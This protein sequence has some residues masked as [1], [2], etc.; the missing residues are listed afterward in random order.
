MEYERLR[1]TVLRGRTLDVGG[2]SQ[3]TYTGLFR[4]E[5]A[6][7]SINISRSVG[8]TWIA[9]LNEPLSFADNEF[10]NVISLNTLEH[11]REDLALLREMVRVLR[12]GGSL[13]L[14]VPFLYRMH[15]TPHDYHRHTEQWWSH[16][17]GTLG[18]TSQDSAIEPLV[19]GP[20]SSA[21]AQLPW[22]RAGLFGGTLKKLVLLAEVPLEGYVRRKLKLTELALAYL[23]SASKPARG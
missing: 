19:W 20:L 9:D 1:G 8:A 10:D 3:F 21:L 18:F 12:P 2:G 11:V 17:L 15:G 7:E 16:V 5:G 4:I 13:I 23:I 6:V 14:T 22:F